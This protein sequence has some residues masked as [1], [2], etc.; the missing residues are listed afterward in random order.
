MSRINTVGALLALLCPLGWAQTE[1]TEHHY[2]LSNLHTYLKSPVGANWQAARAY[3]RSLGGYLA[4]IND[5]F[6]QTFINSRYA[7]TT[8]GFWIGLSD[9]ASEGNYV[10]DS[11]EGLTYG[12]WA[13]GQPDNFGNED[14]VHA[15]YTP[16]D[17]VWHDS[18]SPGVNA[19][20]MALI[21]LASGDRVNFDDGYPSPCALVPSPF[22]A[23]GNPDGVSWNGAGN[24]SSN[25]AFFSS[26]GSGMPANGTHCLL[27]QGNGPLNVPLGG[28]F[29][30]PAAPLANEVRIPIPAGT[31]GVSFAWEFFT[32]E[33]IN[34]I[35]NDGMSVAVVDVNGSIIRDLLY[36]DTAWL[37]TQPAI[38]STFCFTIPTLVVPVAELGPQTTSASLPPLPSLAYLSIVCWNGSDNAYS[39]AA[40]VDAIQFWGSSDFI[41][42]ITAPSGPGSISILDSNGAA[43]NTYVN[44][45]TLVPG[46]FPFGWLFGLDIAPFDLIA[47][48]N[49][50]PP[51]RGTLNSFGFSNY[52]IP[53]GVPPG[54]TL[55]ALGLH[56]DAAGTFINH[57]APEFF[58]TQ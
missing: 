33:A 58:L 17:L 57:S 46:A 20:N 5:S 42:K 50:T 14:Y 45:I 2:N 53:S 35:Y 40:A 19:S 28:Y 16:G 18:Q 13:P 36:V 54:I 21:E 38:S 25:R 43:G 55:Y 56:F 31:R 10:W 37:P 30:R 15:V 1:P 44:A 7:A 8:A 29:P 4:S 41:L 22:G 6:E 3:S 26:Y 47:Q 51:F 49:S 12:H 48:A 11:G 23:L 24:N 32:A 34:S 52:T 27:L 39:S 9:A